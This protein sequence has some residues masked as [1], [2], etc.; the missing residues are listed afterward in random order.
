MSVCTKCDT[1]TISNAG[2]TVCTDCDL[3]TESNE[4]RTECGQFTLKLISRWCR[5]TKLISKEFSFPK[6]KSIVLLLQKN[7]SINKV[8]MSLGSKLLRYEKYLT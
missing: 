7:G 2:A 3:G 8:D 6:S 4:D 1:N 5:K